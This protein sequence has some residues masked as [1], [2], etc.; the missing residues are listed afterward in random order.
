M[1]HLLNA[2]NIFGTEYNWD[3]DNMLF[4]ILAVQ[5]FFILVVL[6]FIIVLLIRK[7]MKKNH[8]KKPQTVVHSTD[9]VPVN[10]PA[11]NGR[12]MM[13]SYPYSIKVRYPVYYKQPISA[14]SPTQPK[15]PEQK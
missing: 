13:Y 9:S 3:I 11:P 6:T 1:N 5:V 7:A 8:E 15:A 14:P 12:N 4:W 10:L 2:V